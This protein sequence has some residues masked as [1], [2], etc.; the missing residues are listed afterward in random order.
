MKALSAQPLAALRQALAT[1]DTLCTCHAAVC[2]KRSVRPSADH[3]EFDVEFTGFH[4]GLSLQDCYMDVLRPCA[5]QNYN[6]CVREVHSNSLGDTPANFGLI[7]PCSYIVAIDG[8][9]TKCTFSQVLQRL[10]KSSRPLKVSFRNFYIS[11]AQIMSEPR[12]RFYLVGGSTVVIQRAFSFFER[13]TKV[14]RHRHL[15][16]AFFTLYR[17]CHLSQLQLRKT[18][19]KISKKE[20]DVMGNKLFEEEIDDCD[21]LL[22]SIPSSMHPTESVPKGYDSTT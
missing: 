21:S 18:K 19:L 6:A 14:T 17:H 1:D 16:R 4:M 11:R 8:D 9:T 7:K 2:D 20:P 22:E 12:P 5:A 15:Q 3:L 13:L 10:K